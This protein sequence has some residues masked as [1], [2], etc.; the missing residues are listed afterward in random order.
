MSI[1]GFD[2][3]DTFTRKQ[4]EQIRGVDLK[5]VP[6]TEPQQWAVEHTEGSQA[7]Y[8]DGCRCTACCRIGRRQT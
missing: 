7:R 4:L 1:D 8:K 6:K 3:L 2:E 5:P